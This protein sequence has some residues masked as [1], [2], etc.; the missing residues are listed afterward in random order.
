[1]VRGGADYFG[2]PASS[3]KGP[4]LAAEDNFCQ[5]PASCPLPRAAVPGPAQPSRPNLSS[6]APFITRVT[7]PAPTLDDHRP[8]SS[9]ADPREPAG[10]ARASLGVGKSS[11]PALAALRDPQRAARLRRHQLLRGC[12]TRGRGSGG[13]RA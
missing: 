12:R 4:G 3:E 9:P 8:A 5:Q 2:L 11:S 1:M 6:G 13:L 7:R 10:R